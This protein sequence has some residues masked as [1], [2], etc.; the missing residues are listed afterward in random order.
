M[1]INN[2]S[3]YLFISLVICLYRVISLFVPVGGILSH[4]KKKLLD[5]ILA[6]IS[7]GVYLSIFIKN[8]L[9]IYQNSIKQI[10]NIIFQVPLL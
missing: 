7:S 4:E 1:L 5:L 8:H 10:E 2:I 9:K 6:L 3:C